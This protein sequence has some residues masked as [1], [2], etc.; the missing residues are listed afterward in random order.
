MQDFSPSSA[1][2]KRLA[3]IVLIT[4]YLG[5][6]TGS[7]KLAVPP[8]ATPAVPT[9]P[10]VVES[11]AVEQP[12]ATEVPAGVEP[13]IA[14]NEL[15]WERWYLQ[16]LDGNRIGYTQVVV[17]RS[18]IEG[19][20]QRIRI[21]RTDCIEVD[22]N[23]ATTRFQRTLESLE[24]ADGRLIELSDLSQSLDE[25]TKTAGKRLRRKFSA[26]TVKTT[27]DGE[28]KTKLAFD[29]ADDVWGLM[30]LQAVLMRQPPQTGERLQ[31]QVFVPQLYK[32][33]QAELLAGP[34][35]LTALPGGQTQS[36]LAVDITLRSEDN[37][38]LSRNWI[39]DR[40]EVLKTVA[41]SGPNLSTFW[42]PSQVAYRTR[43][44][45]ALADLLSRRVSLTGALPTAESRQAI[46]AVNR[47]AAAKGAEVFSL[48]AKSATQSVVSRNALSAEVTV[49]RP[50][51]QP[52]DNS[53]KLEPA[54]DPQYLQAS[55][56][57]PSDN[58]LLSSL[59]EEWGAIPEPADNSSENTDAAN[60]LR[61][62]AVRLTQRVHQEI[63]AT[64]LDR[65]VTGVLQTLQRKSGDCVEH[66]LLLT[67][68]LRSQ[69]IPARAAI[70]LIIDP[71]APTQM[72]FYTWTEAWL[73]GRWLPLDSTSGD[74]AG[75]ERLT[76]FESSLASDNP[77]EAILPTFHEMQ[78]LQ[79]HVKGID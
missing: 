71:Q 12:T 54:P 35:D 76:F 52:A 39:N 55:S 57:I 42:T 44:E 15:P 28:E 62:L 29:W 43:D 9:P 73:D 3:L 20:T 18:A 70:G 32:I 4:T 47:D 60:A 26:D 38:M 36:L 17:N 34:F 74:I 7:D 56:L 33:A 2:R 25:T 49:T 16:Y 61:E 21:T 19:D 65:S 59:A 68:L 14:L 63:A 77:Y 45:F 37:G 31:A 40:G 10:A 6:D 23:G 1:W 69:K 13:W 11:T 5:C 78:G 24:Y 8:P 72:A 53:E 48:L 50:D 58:P 41:L 27:P 64:P 22:N 51:S 79:V 67:S 66:T 75:P 30:G 46:Y